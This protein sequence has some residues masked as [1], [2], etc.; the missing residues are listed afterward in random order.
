MPLINCKINIILTSSANFFIL[1]GIVDGQV[2]KF[3]ITD[4]KFHVS[5]VTLSTQDNAKLLQQLKPSFKKTVSWNNY[6]S[7][8]TMP[9]SNYFLDYLIYP[10]F[11]GVNKLFLLSFENNAPKICCK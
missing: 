11:Q 10:S 6:Q 4:T 9:A 5:V 8:A 3:A 2:P 1:A 7:K